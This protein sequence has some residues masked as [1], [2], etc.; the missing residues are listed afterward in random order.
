MAKPRAKSTPLVI[1]KDRTEATEVADKLAKAQLAIIELTAQREAALLAATQGIAEPFNMQIEP[2]QAAV[3]LGIKKLEAWLEA[4]PGET[5]ELK[6]TR[7]GLHRVGY[8]LGKW[9]T[10][11]VGKTKWETVVT[12]LKTLREARGK[13]LRALAEAFSREVIEVNK[14]AIIDRR[15]DGKAAR[16]FRLIGVKVAQTE[17]FFFEPG[18]NMEGAE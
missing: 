17:T 13:R 2:L 1:P 7:L 14:Q 16:F 12:N 9:A 15:D 11:T 6:S 18:T 3:E 4:N 10:A 5:G 8:Q